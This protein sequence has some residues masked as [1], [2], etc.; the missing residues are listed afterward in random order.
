MMINIPGYISELLFSY[1]C[2]VL[3]GLGGFISNEHPATINR[4]SHEFK[5]PFHRLYFNVHLKSDDGL[6]VNYISQKE[7]IAYADARRLVE[8]FV[9]NILHQLQSGERIEFEKVGFLSLNEGNNI[10]FDQDFTINYNTQSFGLNSFVSPPVRREPKAERI[11]G[12][13]LPGRKEPAKPVDRKT[14]KGSEKRDAEKRR[15]FIKSPMIIALLAL[16]VILFGWGLQ[17]KDNV[18]NYWENQASF[19]PFDRSIPQYQPRLEDEALSTEN[20]SLSETVPVNDLEENENTSELAGETSDSDSETLPEVENVVPPKEETS[21]KTENTEAAIEK[22][23]TPPPAPASR[24][25][26]II[27][28][29]F[30]KEMNAEKLVSQLRQKGYDA[31]IAD[32]NS[33]G[34]LRVAYASAVNLNLA[35]EKLRAI[36]DEDN[37]D[38][39][40]LKK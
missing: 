28:G 9:T 36:R 34:M 3:P 10:S 8:E 33:N 35:K 7:E 16:I 17:N 5:P 39:W 2:V 11:A 23:S 12:L 32:T 14:D 30:S 21:G 37:A 6:L 25:Y 13:I 24:Q 20:N 38:A 22:I 4:L 15:V 1:E 31:L 40:I 29:S 27:A 19:F 26:Y 18:I